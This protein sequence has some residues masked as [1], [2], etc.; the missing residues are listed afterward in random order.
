MSQYSNTQTRAVEK[1]TARPAAP[2][3]VVGVD[4]GKNWIQLCGQDARGTVRLTGKYKPEKLRT[5]LA[6]LP[7][8]R[9]G[10]EA[11]GRAHHWA[12]VLRGYGHDVKL[13]APQFVKAYVKSN[14]SDRADAEA[15][16]E[17]VQRPTMRFVGVKS[18][19]QQDQQSLHRVRALAVAQR[20]A[21]VN[22]V[23]GLLAEYGVE[24][25]QG[26]SRVRAQLPAIL[27]DGENG[28]SMPF[29]ALLGGLYEALVQWDER[30]ATLEAQV[31]QWA[32]TDEQVRRLMSIPGIGPIT[33]TA[34][35][36]A[37][38]EATTFRHGRE[39]A[40]WLGLAPRQHS[41]GGREQ[42]LGISKRGD[43]YVRSL[44]IHGAR[45]VLRVSDRKTD[46]RSRWAQDVLKRRHKNIAAVAL[47]N[48]MAR[49]AHALL[50]KQTYYRAD[51][52]EQPA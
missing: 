20:T 38:G 41:T 52:V 24:I 10:L 12:R 34:L 3:T 15:I 44:L 6:Q 21:L 37:V 40:A 23:R 49:T 43:K 25:G 31:M 28:L 19:A 45:A 46:Q 32:K 9:I 2:I 13:M 42:L 4:L 33:A 27:E 36:A 35:L 50:V 1:T 29:R 48:R 18:V 22:Q 8:C 17:A 47:A 26:R 16:C 39:M 5:L 11:C 30:I 14:K 51:H 7:P